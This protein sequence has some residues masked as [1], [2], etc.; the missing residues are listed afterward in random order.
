MVAE[1]KV[2]GGG[3]RILSY[4]RGLRFSGSC[5]PSFNSKSLLKIIDLVKFVNQEKTLV[6]VVVFLIK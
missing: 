6:N 3:F 2:P 5:G 1:V 4:F